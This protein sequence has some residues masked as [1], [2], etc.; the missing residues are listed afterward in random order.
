MAKRRPRRPRVP[1]FTEEIPPIRGRRDLQRVLYCGAARAFTMLINSA[2]L[3][4][5]RNFRNALDLLEAEGI[6]VTFDPNL[7]TGDLVPESNRMPV[8]DPTDAEDAA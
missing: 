4:L 2:L 1:S 7:W 6:R 3:D 5:R 8:A